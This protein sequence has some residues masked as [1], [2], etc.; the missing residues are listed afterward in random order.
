MTAIVPIAEPTIIDLQ[1]FRKKMANALFTQKSRATK[2]EHAWMVETEAVHR[3][4]T[5]DDTAVLP[6]ASIEPI[7]LIGAALS[8]TT[9]RIYE[10]EFDAYET[11]EHSDQE[12]INVL[13]VKFPTVLTD[14][15]IEEGM[16]P[17]TLTGRSAFELIER[18]VTSSAVA[19]KT[20]LN[21]VKAVT[22]RAYVPNGS[23]P[24][25]YVQEMKRD[26]LSAAV[27][28]SGMIDDAFIILCAQHT[29]M[30]SGHDKEHI[31]T[32]D[33]GWSTADAAFETV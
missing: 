24:V 1:D 26:Q 11:V 14:L 22:T 7:A 28:K 19:T 16:L 17:L 33:V 32:I 29:F 2:T 30:Q 15:K 21:L 10:R 23:G 4:C 27:D 20:Y 13:Q 8:A 9:Y 31:G 5:G 3:K 18:K 12:I 6:K 25:Q